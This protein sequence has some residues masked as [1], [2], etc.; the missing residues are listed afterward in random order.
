[1][2]NPVAVQAPEY[3]LVEGLFWLRRDSQKVIGR[4]PKASASP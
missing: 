3:E 2:Q 1:M 4:V